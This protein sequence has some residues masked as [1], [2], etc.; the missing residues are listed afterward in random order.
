MTDIRGKLKID[1]SF[2]QKTDFTGLP[3]W[4]KTTAQWWVDGQITDEDFIRNVK[5][6]KDSGI[7]R[8]HQFD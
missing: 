1:E 7:I 4:F 6:L 3:E 5:Y 8:D 2:Y